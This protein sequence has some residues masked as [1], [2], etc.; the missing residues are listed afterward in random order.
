MVEPISM[1]NIVVKVSHETSH[2]YSIYQYAAAAASQSA[3]QS[4]SKRVE[5]E[6]KSPTN[7]AKPESK[8][9]K[10]ST[11]EK[12]QGEYYPQGY[13]NR[14]KEKDKTTQQNSSHILDVRV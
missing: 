10:S 9:T 12:S 11:E 13:S 4:T 2:L 14:E 3:S 6:L 1:Q 7:V 5:Q 8:K